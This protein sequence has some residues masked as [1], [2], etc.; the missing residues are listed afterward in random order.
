MLS[1]EY[2]E[3]IESIVKRTRTLEYPEHVETSSGS[4]ET[5]D[6][7]QGLDD[8]TIADCSPFFDYFNTCAFQD[9]NS[10]ESDVVTNKYF[11]PEVLQAF[12]RRCMV[13]YPLWSG[14]LLGPLDRYTDNQPPTI[15]EETSLSNAPAEDGS[16][17]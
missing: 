9:E 14:V 15:V 11:E 13:I 2:T 3:H 4:T 8:Q 5:H 6:D 7:L 1:T 17:L 16:K 10:N 12:T